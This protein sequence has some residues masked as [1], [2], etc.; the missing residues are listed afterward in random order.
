MVSVPTRRKGRTEACLLDLHLPCAVPRYRI[1]VLVQRL[2]LFN[3]DRL[4]TD[5]LRWFREVF[6][7]TFMA[8]AVYLPTNCLSYL[9]QGP[10]EIQG[11]DEIAGGSKSDR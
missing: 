3:A 5:G 7:Q 1:E 2:F 6:P 4:R 9:H 11:V 8:L 10:S